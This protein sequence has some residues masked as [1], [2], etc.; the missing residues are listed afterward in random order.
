VLCE[1]VI[2]TPASASK[3]RKDAAK[4]GVVTIPKVL[5]LHPLLIIPEIS[6]YSIGNAEI[7]ISFP[8]T[9][10]VSYT[11]LTLPTSDLV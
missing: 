7:L 1:A 8:I 9:T 5:T 6:A 4:V 10:A 2:I 3:K 11:H